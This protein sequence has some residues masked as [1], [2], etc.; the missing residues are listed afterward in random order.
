[1]PTILPTPADAR[2]LVTVAEARERLQLTK[3]KMT[4][5]LKHAGVPQYHNPRDAR[6]KLVRLADVERAMRQPMHTDA[7]CPA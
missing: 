4:W 3:Y 1:M 7:S 2:D 6:S 5:L